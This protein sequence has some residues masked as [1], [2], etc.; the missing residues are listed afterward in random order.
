VLWEDILTGMLQ[1]D[2]MV[3]NKT[4]HKVGFMLSDF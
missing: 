2:F 4:N 1:F 3:E